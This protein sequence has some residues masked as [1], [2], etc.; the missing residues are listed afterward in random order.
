MTRGIPM[1]CKST[2]FAGV[3]DANVTWPNWS[4]R[5]NFHADQRYEPYGGGA[6]LPN[7]V[8]V[9]ANATGQGKGLHAIGSGWGFADLAATDSWMVKIDNF[10]S[11]LTYVVGQI[12]TPLLPATVGAGLTDAWRQKQ[13]N[14]VA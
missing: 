12:G 9:V 2:N 8:W 14:P 7:L 1:I 13:N 10:Q 3:N 5:V 11:A 6:A 4:E